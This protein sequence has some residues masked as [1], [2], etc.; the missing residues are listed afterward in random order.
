MW[1]ND[2]DVV[3][4]GLRASNQEVIGFDVAVDYSFFVNFL[5]ASDHLGGYQEDCLQIELSLACLK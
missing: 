2:V 3:S 1:V 4:G 5:Y